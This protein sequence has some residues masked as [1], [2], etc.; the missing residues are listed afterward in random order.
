MRWLRERDGCRPRTELTPGTSI[1]R[2]EFSDDTAPPGWIIVEQQDSGAQIH[3]GA[4]TAHVDRRNYGHRVVTTQPEPTPASYAVEVDARLRKGNPKAN[5]W[6][7][8]C[9]GT[10][11]QA[12]LF[13]MSSDGFAGIFRQD[14]ERVAA[15]RRQP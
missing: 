13:L 7:V 9:H 10:I 8:Q 2:Q 3:D 4:V 12:Y 15:A 11:D 6:G 5:A 14:G 1:D